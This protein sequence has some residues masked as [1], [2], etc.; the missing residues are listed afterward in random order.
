MSRRTSIRERKRYLRSAP[1]ES[2][3]ANRVRAG[4]GAVEDGRGDEVDRRLDPDQPE[5]P[6]DQ[7]G[8]DVPAAG[9]RRLL[10]EGLP[11][12]HRP[13]GVPRHEGEGVLLGGDPFH[14]RHLR[15]PP[16]HFGVGQHAEIEPLHA[17]ED[18]VGDPVGLRGGEDEHHVGRRLLERLQQP[19]EGLLRQ[20]VD[21]VDD[22]DLVPEAGGG[23][24]GVLAQAAD[25][26]DAG[27]GGPVDLLDVGPG[28][29]LRA[30]G[31]G[32]ARGGSRPLFAV[33]RP[34]ED[35]GEGGL[36]DAAGSGEQVGVVDL[37]RGDGV[38]EG[39]GDVPLPDDLVER[40][41]APLPRERLVGHR[42]RVPPP[43]N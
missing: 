17:G 31:A 11:V 33:E 24:G 19:V 18:R 41:R 25:V 37:P 34:G 9:N 42:F 1:R 39:A 13:E 32:Q 5:H 35:P 40:L 22:V 8:G 10:E 15:E 28:A 26:V 23:V 3:A 43:A 6:F 36:A 16:P 14:A 7:R 20:H 12:A 30:R 27:V 21:L 38:G 2:R 4:A 29:D